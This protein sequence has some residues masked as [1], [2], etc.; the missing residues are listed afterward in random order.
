VKILHIEIMEI[1][2][3]IQYVL[4]P[5]SKTLLPFCCPS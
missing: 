4:A 3:A 1:Q 5:I 2:V